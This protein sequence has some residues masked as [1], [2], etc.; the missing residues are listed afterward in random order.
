MTDMF[1][2]SEMI[3]ATMP[4]LPLD[5]T[6]MID[7]AMKIETRDE[8]LYRMRVYIINYGL[9]DECERFGYLGSLSHEDLVSIDWELENMI[10]RIPCDESPDADEDEIAD[11]PVGIEI[12]F[13][14]SRM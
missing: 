11:F 8:L 6:N 14:Q 9:T 3:G 5:G 10:S 13:G 12:S 2:G 1:T 7:Q 4:D